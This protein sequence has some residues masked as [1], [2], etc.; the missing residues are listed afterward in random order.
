MKPFAG[1]LAQLRSEPPPPT[2]FHYSTL[3]G[4]LGIVSSK[5]LWATDIRFLNDSQELRHFGQLLRNAVALR[6]SALS[7]PNPVLTQ[8]A[9]WLPTRLAD[10]PLLFVTSLT[11]NGNLL[12]QWRGYCPHGKGVSLGFQVAPIVTRM[13]PQGFSLARCIYDPKRQRDLVSEILDAVLTYA[14][15]LG[16]DP[17]TAPGESFRTAFLDIEDE[18][19]WL[20]AI[21]KD[22]SFSEEEEWRLISPPFS[23]YVS[24]SVKYREGKSS[25]VPYFEIPLTA[26]H[27]ELVQLQTVYIGPT[28]TPNLSINAASMYLSNYAK[29][30]HEGVH[31][32][33]VPHR[34]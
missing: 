29:A 9:E 26:H 17:T 24:P 5:A 33:L 18:L 11:K 27:E 32:S 8:L 4:L 13:A 31:N 3:A 10:G 30:P 2:L 12:S 6:Q 21:F 19:L 1:L 25:L 22:P 15:S 20:A 7:S 23:N 34:G 28:E 16:P 14:E